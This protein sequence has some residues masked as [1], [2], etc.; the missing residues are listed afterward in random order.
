MDL[1][2][3]LAR[4]L[5]FVTGKGGTGKTSFSAAFAQRAAESGRKT[6]LVEVDNHA[7]SLP[8]I[9]GVPASYSPSMVAPN[10]AICNLTWEQALEDWLALNVPV[11][12]VSRLIMTNR[13]V[14]TF[15]VATPGAH[16]TVILSKVM[17]MLDEWDTVV[18]DLPASGHAISLL[19]VPS[20]T[21]RMVKSGPIRKRAL[22]ILSLFAS[23][24]V[25]SVL[26]SLP[27][28]MVVNE[29]LETYTRLRKE[30]P[31][32]SVGAVVLN[33]SSRPSLSPF[34]EALLEALSAEPDLSQA[35]EELLRAG[36]WEA[37]LEAATAS[38][39]QRLS[40]EI[41]SMI[42][43][44]PRLGALGGF[45]GGPERIIRQMAS[46]LAREALQ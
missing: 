18:V 6:V 36:R 11:E 20:I 9:L 42:L 41:D 7:P 27:E 46:Q 31:E 39:L 38:S 33:R 1:N 28:D 34:E 2:E 40:G 15:L 4:R 45:A 21:L 25:T 17:H 14:Q 37:Q 44:F 13:I 30:V 29:T 23:P 35:E 16:E 10:L 19:R 3:L 5:V 24:E 32:L 43:E 22:E 12:R 8:S 26:V